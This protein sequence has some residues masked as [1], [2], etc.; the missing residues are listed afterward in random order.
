MI[1]LFLWGS[2]WHKAKFSRFLGNVF[3]IIDNISIG[4]TISTRSF[5]KIL[6][7]FQSIFFSG[8]IRVFFLV[9]PI[10][11]SS[12]NLNSVYFWMTIVWTFDPRILCHSGSNP[13]VQIYFQLNAK[14]CSL[15]G[16]HFLHHPNKKA[17]QVSYLKKNF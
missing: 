3:L 12:W 2:S 11:T 8:K 9:T 16:V 14:H 13:T 17:N 15:F 6:N 7:N 5:F 10:Q 1:K 4:G